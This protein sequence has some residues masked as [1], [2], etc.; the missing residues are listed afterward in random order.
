M[1]LAVEILI[2]LGDLIGVG[3]A[4]LLLIVMILLGI[5]TGIG[6]L[7]KKFA[8]WRDRRFYRKLDEKIKKLKESDNQ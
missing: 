3:A 6:C 5:C 2:T 7:L 4:A 8:I 1:I